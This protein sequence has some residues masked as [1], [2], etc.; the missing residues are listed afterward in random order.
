MAV[1]LVFLDGL[2]ASVELGVVR[3]VCHAVAHALGNVLDDILVD[4]LDLLELLN[5]H[6]ELDQKLPVLL[7]RAVLCEV[8]SILV[9]NVLEV[10][11]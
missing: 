10:A 7:V 5:D 6:V 11:Q 1:Q 8:P 2:D 3:V 9:Q 4:R